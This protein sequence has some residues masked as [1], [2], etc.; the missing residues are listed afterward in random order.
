[1]TRHLT[2]LQ[3]VKFLDSE[4]SDAEAALAAEHL[5]EC[6]GCR[7]TVEELRQGSLR[8]EAFVS[9]LPA[10]PAPFEREQLRL[11]L[12]AAERSKH[13]PQSPEKVMRRFGWG[14]AIA[15]TLAVGILI[16]PR[17]R[18]EL[19]PR[20]QTNAA[21][22]SVEVDGETFIALPYS[23]PDL[24]VGTSRIVQMQ[25]PLSSLADVG[26]VLEPVSNEAGTEG[27]VLADV[28]VG[29]DGQ[30]LGVNVLGFE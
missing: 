3:A 12:V 7:Q 13:V 29:A 30:P 2:N 17:H 16:A 21:V 10:A 19:K 6:A 23:N 8:V 24:P 28:L 14:M 27:S 15:A 1:M 18:E 9:A 5:R 20:A 4:L 11:K 26:I 22:D 25:V